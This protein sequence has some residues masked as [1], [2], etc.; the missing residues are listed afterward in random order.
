MDT[1]SGRNSFL[2]LTWYKTSMN[3]SAPTREL[4]CRTVSSSSTPVPIATARPL[5][6]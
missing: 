4:N 2:V 5:W 6:K 1:V 3:D